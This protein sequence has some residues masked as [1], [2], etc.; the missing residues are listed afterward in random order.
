MGVSYDMTSQILMQR[1][2]SIK[3]SHELSRTLELSVKGV[4]NHMKRTKSPIF[5]FIICFV[6]VAI[7]KLNCF[8]YYSFEPY[9]DE[10]CMFLFV[11]LVKA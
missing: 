4:L 10:V 1:K 6:F 5:F 9:N 11:C 2:E 8:N 7:F 3:F